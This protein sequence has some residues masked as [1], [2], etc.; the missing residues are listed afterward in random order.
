MF[1]G[2][3]IKYFVSFLFLFLFYFVFAE[4]YRLFLEIVI[5]NAL[6]MENIC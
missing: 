6:K 2:K 3:D 4:V 5:F 1:W